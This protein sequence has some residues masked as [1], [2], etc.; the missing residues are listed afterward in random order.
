MT[1]KITSLNIA[2]Y[3]GNPVPNRFFCQEGAATTLAVLFPGLWYTCDMPLLYYPL[4]L[5]LQRGADV[6]QLRT[7][8]TVPSYQSLKPNERANWLFTDALA[9]VRA[10]RARRDYA[11]LLLI[12]KSIGTLAIAHLITTQ[13]GADALTIWLTPLL[14]EPQLVEAASY[15]K[16]PALF[17]AGTGDDLYDAAAMAR[18][19]E[20]ARAEALIIEAAN[21]RLEIPGDLFASLRVLEQIMRG[22]TDFLERHNERML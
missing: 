19:R 17:L 8:Y 16:S 21:H 7:D 20:A 10:G 1:H 22:I 12:G 13:A 15:N 11:R 3:G 6:L 14:R 5:L 4:E 2:G 9:V 18:I